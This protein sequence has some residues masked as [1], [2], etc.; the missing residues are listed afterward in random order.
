MYTFN[1]I[2]GVVTQEEAK[3]KIDEQRKEII[4]E[5]KNLEEQAISIVGGDI[6]EEL[7]KGYTEKQ[8]GR[9]CKNLPAFIIKHLPVV[10]PLITT[11]STLSIKEFQL[12]VT[13][14]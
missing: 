8:S 13:Q 2:W 3:K 7:V 5:T 14:R 11:I 1:K 12:V 4:G 9:D 6:Y 10:L